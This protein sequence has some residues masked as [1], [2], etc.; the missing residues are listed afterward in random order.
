MTISTTRSDHGVAALLRLPRYP[1]L[2]A[3]SLLWHTNR[4]AALFAT[5]LLLTHQGATPLEI[6]LIGALFFAPML[7]G[8]LASHAL[9]AIATPRTVVLT[10]QLA[11][12]PVQTLMCLAVALGSPPL[13]A[14]ALFMLAIG[15]G[16]TVN[17]TSQRM[18]IHD[19][20]GDDLASTA[21]TIEPLLSGVGAMVGSLAT[22]LLVDHLG[23]AGAL[24]TLAVLG[25]LCAALT[26]RIPHGRA[27]PVAAMLNG[28][29]PPRFRALVRHYPMLAAM[30]GVTVVMNLFIFGYTPLVPKIAESLTASASVIGLLA[31][32]PGLGQLAGGVA[33]AT[34]STRRRGVLLFAGC[35]LTIAG[36]VAFAVSASPALAFGALFVTGVGQAGFST[37]QSVM[38]VEPT[39]PA[40]RATALGAVSTAI[41]GMPLGMLMIG[42]VSESLGARGGVLVAAG[43]GLT[44]LAAVAVRWRS[45]W[46]RRCPRAAGQI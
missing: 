33:L 10:L 24:G 18:L 42:L 16:N 26:T 22:G 28:T 1:N 36:L 31:A 39:E 11:L 37:M 21:L 12:V 17:M 2:L 35:G 14:T 15:L 44:T 27:A 34:I 5:T 3:G 13:W 29:D 19:T 8:A 20:V 23:G 25:A 30:I 40:M 41:G 6:Q 43:L 32:A 9:A 7:F 45:T 38:A 46:P 4:W